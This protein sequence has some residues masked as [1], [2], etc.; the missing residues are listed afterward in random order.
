MCEDK[1]VLYVIYA[2]GN[3]DDVR[4]IYDI[5]EINMF[6]DEFIYN[7]VKDIND[8]YSIG[9]QLEY[10]LKYI[11]LLTNYY[12]KYTSEF[13]MEENKS[14]EKFL[15]IYNKIAPEKLEYKEIKVDVD[16]GIIIRYIIDL[17]LDRG[18]KEC[19]DE[20]KKLIDF[21]I[22]YNIHDSTNFKVKVSKLKDKL[23]ELLIEEMNNINENYDSDEI[24]DYKY[25]YISKLSS[26]YNKLDTRNILEVFKEFVNAFNFEYAFRDRKIE[27]RE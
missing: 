17:G 20:C 5:D 12:D 15:E 21:T 7:L 6:F 19:Q 14:L 9:E 16:K 10:H 13:E 3:C 4:G 18:L 27:L 24:L 23:K 11:G 8:N 2:E 1:N 22:Y 26:C 25:T